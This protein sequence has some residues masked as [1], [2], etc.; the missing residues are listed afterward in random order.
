MGLCML[1]LHAIIDI[2]GYVSISMM[3]SFACML[4][5]VSILQHFTKN[6]LL[7][8]HWFL[9]SVYSNT[10]IERRHSCTAHTKCMAKCSMAAVGVELSEYYYS[11]QDVQ[12]KQYKH[13]LK[14]KIPM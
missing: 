12:K 14:G 7:L 8:F 4:H 5:F 3:L 10:C 1:L 2:V 9:L 13:S 6:V 11:L